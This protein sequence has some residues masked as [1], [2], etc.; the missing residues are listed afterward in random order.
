ML[1]LANI[2]MVGSCLQ[3]LLSWYS[4]KRIGV[5]YRLVHVN[6]FSK[7]VLRKKRLVLLVPAIFVSIGWFLQDFIKIIILWFS[8]IWVST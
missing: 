7:L 2:V 3:A 8:P 4:D 5:S 1:V 6:I